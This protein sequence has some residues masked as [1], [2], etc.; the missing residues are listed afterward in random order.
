[1]Q[2]PGPSN[3]VGTV[4]RFN[5]PTGLAL[6]SAAQVLYVADRVYHNIRAVAV[7]SRTV[8]TTFAGSSLWPRAWIT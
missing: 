3:G 8:S 6:D 2:N 1:M 4:A 5:S 7:A